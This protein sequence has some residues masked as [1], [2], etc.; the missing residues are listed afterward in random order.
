M[1]KIYIVEIESKLTKHTPKMRKAV[2]S[3]RTEERAIFSEKDKAI[4]Y[5]SGKYEES[6]T[7]YR[8]TYKAYLHRETENYLS[9]DIWVAEYMDIGG[10]FKYER[11][12]AHGVSWDRPDF[13]LSRGLIGT[14]EYK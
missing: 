9:T 8:D 10:Q 7:I 14:P 6:K 11:H 3:E 13:I 2:F 4:A 1:K 12:I 5:A